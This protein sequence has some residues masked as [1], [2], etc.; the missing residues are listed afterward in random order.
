MCQGM[1]HLK[2]SSK[3][4]KDSDR[5]KNWNISLDSGNCEVLRSHQLN[6]TILGCQMRETSELT[7][8]W[9]PKAIMVLIPREKLVA[10]RSQLDQRKIKLPKILPSLIWKMN[11]DSPNSN[12][13]EWQFGKFEDCSWTGVR[14][15][16]LSWY[17]HIYCSGKIIL[18]TGYFE[19]LQWMNIAT[20]NWN[21][22][23]CSWE[24][25]IS[26]IIGSEQ[27]IF[28]VT[29]S[30]DG[31]YWFVNSSYILDTLPISGLK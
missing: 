4:S 22:N 18:Q 26:T 19:L 17:S 29:F 6:C 9:V 13:C 7:F 10:A 24:V 1:L 11:S 25:T 20:C 12:Y 31:G 16:P 30:V 23:P 27:I 28:V 8:Q 21:P 5:T 15:C 14:Q 2:Y 3:G